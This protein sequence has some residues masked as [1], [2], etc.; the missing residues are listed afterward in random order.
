VAA[1]QVVQ[2]LLLQLLAQLTLVEEDLVYHPL[3][4]EHLRGMQVVA[5]AAPE[6]TMLVKIMA[7][8]AEVATGVNMLIVL[9]TL[10]LQLPDL[11][12]PAV[13]GAAAAKAA[14]AW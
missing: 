5:E 10:I 7:E 6:P 4:P 3:L 2:D 13:V 1:E 12:I 14:R 8:L 11:Q 9:L